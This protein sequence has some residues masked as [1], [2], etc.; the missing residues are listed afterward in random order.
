MS[1][2]TPL[3]EWHK[4]HGSIVD[5][6]GWALPVRITNINEEH[7][8][9]R[10]HVGI[11]D[12]SH[13]GRFLIRGE[14][15]RLFLDLVVARNIHALSP[16]KAGYTYVLN[17]EGGFKDD[18]IVACHSD[19]EF[20][21]VCNASNRLKILNWLTTLK[22][23]IQATNQG[24]D[25]TITDVTKYSTMIAVQGPKAIALLHEILEQVPERWR[26]VKTIVKDMQVEVWASG[27][28]YTGERGAE[29]IL[30]E[31]DT[32]KLKEL[33]I[34]LWELL[35][36]KGKPFNILPCGLGSRDT[37]RLEAG[38]CLYGNDITETITAEEAG[39]YFKP[40]ADPDKPFFIGQHALTMKSPRYK[41]IGFILKDKGIP[42]H[43]Y[44]IFKDGEEIGWV[45]SGTVSPLLKIGIG[46]GY[47]K[48]EHAVTGTP[49]QIQ[50]RNKFLN[51]EIKE[52][53]FYDPT[54]YGYKRNS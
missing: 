10:N 14:N 11:F 48:P 34:N 50:V 16:G 5:F 38:L 15:A 45:S 25:V 29:L 13:M 4:E 53:P 12:T 7:K 33:S 42:R 27:T 54:K 36:E 41:R 21:F 24:F 44:K 3:Y 37:L 39:L 23:L 8:A 28:G 17:E 46:M 20:L 22:E 6:A 26:L 47:V 18:V 51:A 40:F 52:F 43:D 2:K 31:E 35:L 19:T 49:I 9:V 1:E 32:G 30:V